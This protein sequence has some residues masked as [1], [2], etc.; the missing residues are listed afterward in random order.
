[1]SSLLLVCTC[2]LFQAYLH[3]MHDFTPWDK[4]GYAVAYLT[5]HGQSDP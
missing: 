3:A 5:L 1:M 2:C 4:R